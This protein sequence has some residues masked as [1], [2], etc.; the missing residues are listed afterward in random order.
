MLLIDSCLLT[1]RISLS[2]GLDIDTGLKVKEEAIYATG[3]QTSI[4]R[5][6]LILRKIIS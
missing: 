1:L 2:I 4:K 5:S 6:N 3:R